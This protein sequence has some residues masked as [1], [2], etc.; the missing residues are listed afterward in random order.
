MGDYK[1]KIKIGDHEFEAEGPAD[2]VQNQFAMFK[3]LL[4]SGAAKRELAEEPKQRTEQLGTDPKRP[5]FDKIMRSE[6]RVISLTVHP[7]SIDEAILLVLLGQ[8]HYRQNDSVT[9]GEI[10]DGLRQS[11]H[12]VNRVDYQLDKL[13][14]EGTV[15]KVGTG[16]ASRYRLTNKGLAKAEEI[17]NSLLL[18]V[19]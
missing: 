15:I 1:L 7:E 6:G 11:G 17:A 14:T 8:R 9:G 16:R 19:P 5:A 12:T 4:G 10:I 2:V 3:E 13:A 18:Q